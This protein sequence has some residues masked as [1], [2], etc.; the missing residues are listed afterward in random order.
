MFE[1]LHHMQATLKTST[2]NPVPSSPHL[3]PARLTKAAFLCFMGVSV[4]QT[5]AAVETK[6]RVD[7]P[8]LAAAKPTP[9]AG[10]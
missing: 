8:V 1:R 3:V 7:M 10:I 4:R 5:F 2:R 9:G 6:N